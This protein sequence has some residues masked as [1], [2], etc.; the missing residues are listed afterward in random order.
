MSIKCGSCRERHASVEDVKYC[1]AEAR[2]QEEEMRALQ[3]AEAGYER[4]LETRYSDVIRWEEEQ[5]RMGA[6]RF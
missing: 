6:F 3:A 1:Y 4:W 2:A 5:E